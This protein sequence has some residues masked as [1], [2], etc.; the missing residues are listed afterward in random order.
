MAAGRTLPALTLV[1]G[2]ARSGKSRHAEA[3]VEGEPGPCTFLATAEAGDR[4]MA[5]RIR[6]HQARRG[7]RWRTVEE[8]LELGAAL[9][10]ESSAEGALL[11]DCLT[12]WLANLMAAERDCE[13]E[14]ERLV[15]GFAGLHGPVVMVS[16][17][18]GCGIVPANPLARRFQDEAGRLNQAVAAAADHVI[19]MAA[20]LPLILKPR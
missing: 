2:G 14:T 5:E 20:G 12:L 19:Y 10:R 16:N 13:A 3:L 17:E 15:A 8:P 18:V 9:G 11:V 6:R 4:E 7:V 1:L